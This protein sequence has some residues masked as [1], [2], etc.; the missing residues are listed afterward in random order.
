MNNK[1][2]MMLGASRFLK[3]VIKAAHELG[4][5]VI[6]CDNDASHY[7]HKLSDEYHVISVLDKKGIL[8]LSKKLK[9]DGIMSFACDAGVTTAA[10]V[11]EQLGLP[12]CGPYKSV[13]IL[14]NKK[15]FRCFLKNNGFNVPNAVGISSYEEGLKILPQFKFPVIVK[16][17]D[18]AGSKGVK[19]IDCIDDFA[20]AYRDAVEHSIVGDVIIEEFIEKKGDSSDTDCFSVDGQLK[21]VSFSN[22]KF[23]INAVNPYAPAAYTWPSTISAVHQKELSSEL[24]RLLTL[25]NMKTS[26][27]NI[28]TRDGVDGKSYIMECT[29][30]GGGNRLAE[31]LEF[32]TGVDMIK[33][34][35]R[36]ALGEPI[37]GLEA[38]PYIGYW[39]IIILHSSVSGIFQKLNINPFIEEYIK[40][41]DLWV[42]QG[43][44]ICTYSGGNE[45]I[46]TL[47]LCFDTSDKMSLVIENIEKY[48]NIITI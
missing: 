16:P 6:T 2:L 22:Q 45:A 28:E 23:D 7:G 17:V 11:A 46:G 41:I 25:L 12:A 29:P 15:K 36:A 18:S 48:I 26:I 14:Q 20:E 42:K 19:R 39:S 1:K 40:E 8:N 27:Y 4:C 3:P 47:V 9:I 37:I 13:C 34:A 10:Y 30:R 33:N 38:K 35:V 31:M 44:R 24:Q 21:F 5:Y 32:A 43:D